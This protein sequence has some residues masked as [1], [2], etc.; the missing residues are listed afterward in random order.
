[1]RHLTIPML[2][3]LML[4]G[5]DQ[6]PDKTNHVTI[7]GPN[8][9]MNISGNGEHIAIK[10]NDGKTQF[11]M[12]SNGMTG[13]PGL[14]S[15]APLYPGAKVLSTVRGTDAHS[16]GGLVS[17]DTRES[18]TDVVAFYKQKA[19]AEGLTDKMDMNQQGTLMFMAG[20]DKR[21]LQVTS[22]PGDGGAGSHTQVTWSGG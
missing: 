13:D 17:F 5:C 8:G 16:T 14:P 20:D 19:A 22:A 21:S 6:K 11:E 7:S 2:A 12:N 15:F 10:S 1:M 3:V 9:S 18:P 4:C